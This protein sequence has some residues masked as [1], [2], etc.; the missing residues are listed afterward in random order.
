MTDLEIILFK[1]KVKDRTSIEK[2]PSQS[3]YNGEV[4]KFFINSNIQQKKLKIIN[5]SFSKN[6]KYIS[7]KHTI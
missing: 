5:F 6:E 1:E 3:I 7:M 4:A 2:T